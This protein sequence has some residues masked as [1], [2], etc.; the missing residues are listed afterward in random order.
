MNIEL[1]THVLTALQTQVIGSNVQVFVLVIRRLAS[2]GT[3]KAG[4]TDWSH[5]KNALLFSFI[6]FHITW[7]I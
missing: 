4:G 2:I 1:L 6:S 7:C 5:F 3:E